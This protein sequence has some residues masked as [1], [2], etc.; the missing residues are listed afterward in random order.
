MRWAG[1]R[2]TGGAAFLEVEL[3]VEVE[4]RR[5]VGLGGG[6]GLFAGAGV[7]FK[8]V[9]ERSLVSELVDELGLNGGGSLRG[10]FVGGRPLEPRRAGI[11]GTVTQSGSSLTVYGFDGRFGFGT[12]PFCGGLKADRAGWLLSNHHFRLSEL[13]GGRPGS[14]ESYPMR[15][16]SSVSS[17]FVSAV[18]EPTSKRRFS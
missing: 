11:R 16:S 10:P 3:F 13:A 6:M 12:A 17:V 14:I 1:L 15:S 5:S 18:V 2:A 7:S 4:R 9:W 8:D